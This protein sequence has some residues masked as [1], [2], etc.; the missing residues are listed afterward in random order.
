[1]LIRNEPHTIVEA[2]NRQL[3]HY[4]YHAGQIIFIAKHLKSADW[5]S[6]SIPRG[7]SSDFVP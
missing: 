7:K 1:M 4:A 6:L 3:T 2:L 5:H